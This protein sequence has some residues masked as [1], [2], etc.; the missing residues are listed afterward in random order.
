MGDKSCSRGCGFDSWRC[1]LDGHDIFHINLLKKLFYLFEKAKKKL[2]RGWVGPF[3]R[4][5]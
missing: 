3:K 5:F 2:K 1:I 4:E